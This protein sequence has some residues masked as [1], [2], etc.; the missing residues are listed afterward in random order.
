MKRAYQDAGVR[1]AFL[2]FIGWYLPLLPS[3]RV[4]NTLEASIALITSVVNPRTLSHP[5]SPCS[6][7]R[8]R[9][10]CPTSSRRSASTHAG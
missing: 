6:S 9:P 1:K 4:D 10:V 3:V 8:S 5:T 2:S 7:C